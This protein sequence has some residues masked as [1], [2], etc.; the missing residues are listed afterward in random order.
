VRWFWNQSCDPDKAS[1]PI[2]DPG[3]RTHAIDAASAEILRLVDLRHAEAQAVAA[4]HAAARPK[5]AGPV[6]RILGWLNKSSGFP[7]TM[8][9]G[10]DASLTGGGQDRP[11]ATGISPVLSG[12]QQSILQWFNKA[13]YVPNAAGTWG[14]VGRNTLIGPGLTN[15]DFSVVKNNY[16]RKISESFN[17]QFRAE[18]F[19]ILNHANFNVPS[20]G[21]GNTNVL[22]G[23]GTVNGSAGLLSQTTTDPRE[24]Q[25]ALK[26]IW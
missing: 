7:R 15:L 8:Y 11:N 19:N 13:A 17:V 5:G 10:S 9:T 26:V 22:N 21:D 1:K 24:I 12:S 6:G 18:L 20:L 3:D 4:T 23:D 2:L 25:F 16:I 14:N